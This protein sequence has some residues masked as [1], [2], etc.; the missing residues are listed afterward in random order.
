VKPVSREEVIAHFREK[1]DAARRK[2]PGS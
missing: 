2:P 1:S